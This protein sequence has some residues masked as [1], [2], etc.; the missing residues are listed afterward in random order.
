M[1]ASKVLDTSYKWHLW[2]DEFMSLES[3]K[4]TFNPVIERFLLQS[5]HW[6]FNFITEH[7]EHTHIALLCH[8]QDNYIQQRSY[9]SNLTSSS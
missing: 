9:Q 2:K 4:S 5:L 7:I 1:I 8:H 3:K 6:S